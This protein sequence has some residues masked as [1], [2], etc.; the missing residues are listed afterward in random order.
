MIGA[1]TRLVSHVSVGAGVS[2][3]ENCL[4]HAGVCIGD[5][6]QIGHRVILQP[7]AVIGADGFS[8]VTA[9]VGSVESA[10]SGGKVSAQ[11]TEILRIN[12]AGTV[13]LEDDVEIG[14]NSCVDRATLGETR[15]RRGTKLDNQVQIGHNITMGENCL[16]AAQV[17][18]AGSTI[19]GD[20]VVMGGQAGVKDHITIGSDTIILPMTGV[21]GDVPERTLLVGFHG[22]PRK[23][24]LNPGNAD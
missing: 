18:I 21:A 7:N 3:G 6:V 13:V 11:N 22:V 15:I 5:A 4:F 24:F 14:A 1:G 23:E 20:R 19:I 16:V 17:G 9:S 2:I 8:Y 10:R 12:S